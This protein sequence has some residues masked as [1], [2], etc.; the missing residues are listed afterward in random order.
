MGDGK[1]YLIVKAR[2]SARLQKQP[3]SAPQHSIL[4]FK[5]I[6]ILDLILHFDW[7]MN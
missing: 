7:Q 3:E 4:L 5:R 6:L 2:M 1:K